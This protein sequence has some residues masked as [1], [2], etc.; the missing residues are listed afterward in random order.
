MKP[1]EA[2]LPGEPYPAMGAVRDAVARA[3]GG[4]R[5]CQY[6]C[7]HR[8][9]GIGPDGS[10]RI[11]ARPQ[12]HWATSSPDPVSEGECLPFLQQPE[13]TWDDMR[14]RNAAWT[15]PADEDDTGRRPT[16]HRSVG[17]V[18]E[19]GSQSAGHQNTSPQSTS[20]RHPC[21]RSAVNGGPADGAGVSRRRGR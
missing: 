16:A 4:D 11:G 6:P 5:R 7:R 2:T 18:S 8:Q 9:L 17:A 10:G 19:T 20:D 1:H 3:G 15:T 13:P 21:H 14:R 12:R